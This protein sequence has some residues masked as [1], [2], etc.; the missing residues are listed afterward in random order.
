MQIFVPNVEPE[1]AEAAYQDLARFA[2]CEPAPT[3]ERIA[4]ISFRHDGNDWTATVGQS[5]SGL[6]V[7][8]KRRKGGRVQVK[9]RLSDAAVVLAIFAGRPYIV[10]TDARPL[11]EKSSYWVNPFMAGQPESVSYFE[12]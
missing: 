11:G 6:R 4:S 3:G 10:V 2:A 8:S 7:E 1:S 9:T 5:L 12:R